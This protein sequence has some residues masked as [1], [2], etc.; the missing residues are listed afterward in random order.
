MSKTKTITENEKEENSK[1]KIY[2]MGQVYEVPATLTIMKAMEFVGYKFT[3]GSGCRAGFCGACSTIYR[4]EGDFRIYTAL[5]CQTMVEEGMVLTQLPFVP[6]DKPEYDINNLVPSAN[7]VLRYFPE[8]AR[9][10]S[11]NACSKV[12][13]QDIKVMDYIQHSLQ[14]QIDRA[15]E[16]SFD[17]VNCGLCAIRCPAEIPQ[18][19]VAQLVRRLHGRYIMKTPAYLGE[20]IKEIEEGKY[21]DGFK[22]FFSLSKDVLEDRYK[23][24][25]K[26][27]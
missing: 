26:E 12:C 14:G 7:A 21:D 27:N 16:E 4:K 3:R 1:V 6:A 13:P 5:A 2:I 19:H 17:C 8:V 25:D 15:A 22:E 20:R 11:C 23:K 9:C 24:R 18:Y 10:L